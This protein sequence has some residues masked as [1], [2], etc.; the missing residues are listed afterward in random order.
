MIQL[1]KINMPNNSISGAKI[2]DKSL[3]LGKLKDVTVA[4]QNNWKITR[5]LN[6]KKRYYK[7]GNFNDGSRLNKF[8]FT[9]KTFNPNKPANTRV[10]N[11]T[12][13]SADQAVSASPCYQN[14]EFCVAISSLYDNAP[15]AFKW[16]VELED[17]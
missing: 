5:L 13:S 6:G 10:V 7:T 11:I 14:G 12:I 15:T 16:T 3:A 8:A 1:L 4:D 17:N 9:N 2:T